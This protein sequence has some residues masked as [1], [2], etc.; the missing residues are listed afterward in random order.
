MK[1][2]CY[3][4][5]VQGSTIPTDEYEWEYERFA[6]MKFEVKLSKVEYDSHGEC[7]SYTCIR[8]VLSTIR[9]E[10][11]VATWRS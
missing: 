9:T 8:F 1:F 6:L 10:D 5:F 3:V 7:D 4:R 11:Y 2:S